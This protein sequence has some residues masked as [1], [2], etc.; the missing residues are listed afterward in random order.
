MSTGKARAHELPLRQSVCF[1]LLIA[2]SFALS[3]VFGAETYAQKCE[4]QKRRIFTPRS[5]NLSPNLAAQISQ[6]RMSCRLFDEFPSIQWKDEKARLD[7]FAMELQN[8]PMA[9]GYVRVLPGAKSRAVAVQ[10]YSS[11]IV[12]YL[13]NSRSIEA[14]Q[15]ETVTGRRGRKLMVQ[16]WTCPQG[17]SASKPS[18]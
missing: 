15:L 3:S 8:A 14:R 2:A 1:H 7:E 11:R 10:K 5:L 12:D 16:L 17:T 13:V 18:L 6:P 9:I 4:A